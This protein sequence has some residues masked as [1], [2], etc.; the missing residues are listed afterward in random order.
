MREQWEPEDLVGAWTLVEDDLRLV[1]NKTG[2]SR[3]GFS[4]LLKFFEQDGRFPRGLEELP[5][6]AVAYVARQVGV[7]ADVVRGYR[8]AGRSVKYHRAQIREALGF[9]EATRGHEAELTAWL[10]AEVAPTEVSDE[11]LREAALARC[12][13]EHIE[14]PGRLDRVVAAARAGATTALCARTL[15]RLP[16]EVTARLER[17]GR[18]AA[19]VAGDENQRGAAHRVEG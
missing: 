19:D 13:V 9:R 12:R 1:A 18:G 11:R 8:W 17:L 4:L 16:A 15:A 14:P 10:A 3:L 2:V 7:E 6:A 5:A